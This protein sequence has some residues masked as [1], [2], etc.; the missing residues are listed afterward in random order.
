MPYIELNYDMPIPNEYLVDHSFSEGKTIPCNYHGPDKLWLHIEKETGK[1]KY[2]PLTAEDMADGRPCPL[3]C[4]FYELDCIEY[5]LIAQLRAPIINELQDDF[6]ERKPHPQ[7]PKIDG[8]PQYTYGWP[9][10]PEDVWDRFSV[11]IIDGKPA[12]KAFSVAQRMFGKDTLM[13]WDNVR[14]KRDMDLRLSDAQ[15]AEDMPQSLKDEYFAYR[16]LLRDF[17]TVMQE[18]NVP[19]HIAYFMMPEHPHN[20][21]P[22]MGDRMGTYSAPTE[23]PKGVI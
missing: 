16:Q 17:P 5:P 8:Y 7:S 18:N 12:I 3:D 19:P 22:T 11:Q 1:E 4:Y 23:S 9:L 10:K 21:L 2:G 14:A 13:P 20:S 6:T 15:V